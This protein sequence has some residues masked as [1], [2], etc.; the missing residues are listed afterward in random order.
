M[1]SFPHFG[2]GRCH[3][4]GFVRRDVFFFF[5]RRRG[6]AT[7]C[8]RRRGEQESAFPGRLDVGLVI[9]ADAVANGHKVKVF[10]VKNVAVLLGQGNESLG[11]E[12]VE[13]LLFDRV[14]AGRVFQIVVAIVNE[15]AFQLEQDTREGEREFESQ[16][17]RRSTHASFIAR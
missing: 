11:E 6:V 13:L 3:G 1:R 10:R 9:A 2:L 14:V 7:G 8:R 12:I 4:V 16:L 17:R 15:K 5:F